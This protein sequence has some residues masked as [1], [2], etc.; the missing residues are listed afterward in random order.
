MGTDIIFLSS[1]QKTMEPHQQLD[2]YLWETC[3]ERVIYK[4]IEEE[5]LAF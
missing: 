5:I 2:F 3:L 4:F 1:I